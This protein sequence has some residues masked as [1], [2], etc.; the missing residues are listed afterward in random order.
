MGRICTTKS[1]I[2]I[3][4]KNS[5]NI[6]FNAGAA[7]QTM[8]M[9]LIS[10]ANDVSVWFT[11]FVLVLDTWNRTTLC[12]Q[13]SA[14]MVLT[15][16]RNLPI[17]LEHLL[18]TTSQIMLGLQRETSQHEH[19]QLKVT[20]QQQVQR[21]TSSNIP[22]E[23]HPPKQLSKR[24]VVNDKGFVRLCNVG[25]YADILKIGQCLQTRPSG[26]SLGKFCT[27]CG[28]LDRPT[29]SKG[30]C[31]LRRIRPGSKIGP[32]KDMS[33]WHWCEGAQHGQPDEVVLGEGVHGRSSKLSTDSRKRHRNSKR[34]SEQWDIRELRETCDKRCHIESQGRL[35]AR[36]SANPRQNLVCYSVLKRSPYKQGQPETALECSTPPGGEVT[37][38]PV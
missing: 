38:Q 21:A 19:Q 2:N 28:E 24:Q 20:C 25:N 29:N 35:W 18:Q 30:W 17:C 31:I 37:D 27:P 6:H 4:Y 15:S 7:S 33:I 1:R 5:K 34:K 36:T 22:R 11:E 10:S 32:V 14:P 8:I 12:R 26:N 23:R 9:D 16:C 13:D 3:L